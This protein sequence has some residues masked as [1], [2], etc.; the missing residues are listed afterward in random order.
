M[1]PFFLKTYCTTG[2]GGGGK[3]GLGHK[4]KTDAV[5]LFTIHAVVFTPFDSW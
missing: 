1:S 4:T 3:V 2:R 5:E